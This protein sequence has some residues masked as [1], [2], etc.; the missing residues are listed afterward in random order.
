MRQMRW[1]VVFCVALLCLVA[2]C[3]REGA[4]PATG[5][6]LVVADAAAVAGIA[7]TAELRARL[8]ENTYAYVRIPSLWNYARPDGRPL[9]VAL[10]TQVHADLIAQ[11]KRA[12]SEDPLIEKAGARPMAQ[13]L[14]MDWAGPVEIA[15]VDAAGYP[16]LASLILVSIPLALD[17]VDALNARLAALSSTA[18]LLAK[19]LD[20]QGRGRFAEQTM[21]NALHFDAAARRLYLLSGFGADAKKLDEFVATGERAAPASMT[22][23]ERG[24]DPL[25]NGAFAWM[26]MSRARAMFF[27]ATPDALAVNR[28]FVDHLD[29]VAAGWGTVN[30]HGRLRFAV[31]APKARWLS[32]LAAE[33][34]PAALTARGD[35][36]YALTMNLPTHAQIQQFINDIGANFGAQAAV[37]YAEVMAKTGVLQLDA[38]RALLETMGPDVLLFNDAAGSYVAA[39]IRDWS[40][41]RTALTRFAEGVKSPVR[42][43]TIEGVAVKSMLVPSWTSLGLD[44]MAEQ[45]AEG[46]PERAAQEQA[47]AWLRLYGR[48]GTHLYWVEDGNYVLYA[49]VPQALVDRHR[50]ATDKPLKEWLAAHGQDLNDTVMSLTYATEDV[51]RAMYYTYLG[52]LD[53]L[54]DLVG[55]Q[56]DITAMPSASALQLPRE[57]TFGLA[58][59]AS[60][61]QLSLDLDYEQSPLEG[62]STSQAGAI[63][64]VAMVG[65]LAG[66]AVPAYDDYTKRAKIAEALNGIANAKVA[67]AEYA[68]TRGRMPRSLEQAGIDT[69]SPPTGFAAWSFDGENLTLVLAEPPSPSEFD[70]NDTIIV[71]AT[72]DAE[73]GAP[74]WTCGTAG[75][76]VIERFLPARCRGNRDLTVP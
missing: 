30:E 47:S 48:T 57:G 76:T 61:E 52:V 11:L 37:D 43:L 4:A 16:S 15:F 9:D 17:S 51:H 1:S 8:P 35:T 10:S 29:A 26:D 60:T 32:Y 36:R 13:L 53:T 34:G 14:L 70:A 68:M 28:D 20:A 49:A 44:S 12:V 38:W 7:R 31:R 5:A 33:P 42:E 18:P 54:A 62:F 27:P 69:T 55:A 59:R 74:E 3:G 71:H 63:T 2:G 67:I 25:G 39:H 50:G 24:I 46:S 45:A 75:T 58:L 22:E 23:L 56:I 72:F 65:I 73:H 40:A 66:I 6:N 21:P 41:Y 19:P 64:T